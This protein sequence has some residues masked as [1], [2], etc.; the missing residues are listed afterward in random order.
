MCGKLKVVGKTQLI[1]I[2]VTTRS[3]IVASH[4]VHMHKIVMRACVSIVVFR[5]LSVL[6]LR[7]TQ[8]ANV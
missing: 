8:I 2:V 7:A 5:S 3:H 1:T 6:M 4:V